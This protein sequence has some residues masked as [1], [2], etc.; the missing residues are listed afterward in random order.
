MKIWIIEVHRLRKNWAT[1]R[2][3][4]PWAA[5]ATE[6]S[7][8]ARAT[9]AKVA[10][11][12]VKNYLADLAEQAGLPFGDPAQFLRGLHLNITEFSSTTDD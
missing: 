6:L 7:P 4:L 8:A 12:E 10:R 5:L 9:L 3:E 1:G 2:R 11:S